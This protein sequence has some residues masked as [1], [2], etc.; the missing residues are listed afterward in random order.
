MPVALRR[1]KLWL[2][3]ACAAAAMVAGAAA[4][5]SLAEASTSTYCGGTLGGYKECFGNS[6]M[7]YQAYGWGDQ[8]PVRVGITFWTGW[9]CSSGAGSGVYSQ[10]TQ[11]NV[12]AQPGIRN[13][14]GSVNNVHGV[15]LTH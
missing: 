3:A 4:L 8:G 11:T 6:R 10:A 5:P 12:A 9:S 1:M 2:A 7:L 15:A 14:M 13:N